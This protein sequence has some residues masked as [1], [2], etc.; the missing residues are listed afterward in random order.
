[1]AKL[2]V[3][4]IFDPK[5]KALLTAPAADVPSELFGTPEL[6]QF[7]KDMIQAMKRSR[8]VGLAAPQ[9][10]K[11]WR[12]AIISRQADR[13]LRQ[14][15]V[16]LNPRLQRAGGRTVRDEEGCLSIPDVFGVV[17]RPDEVLVTAFDLKGQPFTLEA[18]GL[19]A[20]VLQHELDHLQG[21]LFIER[22][23]M[24]SQGADRL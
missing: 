9:V 14:D 1:M 11:S 15:L 7:A 18:Y 8:G 6:E 3:W 13:S 16:L 4:T 22:A 5:Q 19:F 2:P 24:I 12:M 23:E 20:R 21:I 17:A 10:G